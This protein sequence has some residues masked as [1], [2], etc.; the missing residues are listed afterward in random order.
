MRLKEK[1]Q[2]DLNT[3]MDNTS[4]QRIGTIRTSAPLNVTLDGGLMDV[5]MLT[6]TATMKHQAVRR[7]IDTGQGE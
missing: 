7:P 3:T 6:L 4:I 5:L 2:L 1:H